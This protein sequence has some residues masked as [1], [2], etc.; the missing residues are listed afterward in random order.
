M[1][2]RAAKED[3]KAH[4]LAEAPLESCGVI[5]AGN[6]FALKNLAADP[7]TEFRIDPRFIAAYYSEID[8][9]C[10][11]HFFKDGDFDPRFHPR[12]HGPSEADMV[13]QMTMEIPWSLVVVYNGEASEPILWGHGIQEPILG[14]PYVSGVSDCYTLLEDYWRPRGLVLPET[15]RNFLWWTDP[16]ATSPFDRLKAEFGFRSV[17]F[18]DVNPGDVLLVSIRSAVVNHVAIYLGDGVVLHHLAGS[19][20]RV[21]PVELLQR[22]GKIVDVVRRH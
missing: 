2:P 9:I 20:S 7:A 11:S 15:P 3:A 21:D 14:R 4:A 17:D 19:V 5:M 13:A 1:L 6:Y 16:A 8:W 12:E 18:A 10:H 22:I